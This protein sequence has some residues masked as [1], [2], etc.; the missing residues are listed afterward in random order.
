MS[1]SVDTSALLEAWRRQYPPDV[2]PKLWENLSELISL[3]ELVAT[4][5]VKLELE[6][7]DDEVLAWAK[8]QE[9][10]FVPLDEPIQEAV[11]EI[12]RDH[13]K[14]IDTR[15][16]RSGADPFVIAL[17]KT[18]GL[19]VVTDEHPTGSATRPHIPDV[20]RALGIPYLN[21]LDLI[22]KHGWTF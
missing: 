4:E 21:M 12:L 16:G 22:R 10:L 7:K 6:R 9:G 2:F 18:R 17:A 19:T 13:K 11:T 14:L 20:C 15:R 8:A 5:E 1:Y 3:G